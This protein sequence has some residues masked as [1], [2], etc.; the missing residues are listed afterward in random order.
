VFDS[1]IKLGRVINS[2]AADDDK[3]CFP[4]VKSR[5]DIYV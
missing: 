2:V 5:L 3:D 1:T 4:V